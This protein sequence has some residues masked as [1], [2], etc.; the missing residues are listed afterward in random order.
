M[1][2]VDFL[3]EGESIIMEGNANMKQALGITKGGKLYLTNQRLVFKAGKL[4]FGSKLDEIPLGD[5]AMTGNKLD[6][7]LPTPNM[8]KVSTKGGKTYQF[9]VTGKQKAEWKEKIE[10]L[11][12]SNQ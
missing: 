12:N 9:I 2:K 8:I 4:N 7:F 3:Q 11:V 10:N 1:A 5:I 6:I